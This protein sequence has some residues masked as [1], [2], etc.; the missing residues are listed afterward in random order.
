MES[1]GRRFHRTEA[2][3]A[4]QGAPT[5][6]KEAV[7]TARPR[8]S[9]RGGSLRPQAEGGSLQSE[10]PLERAWTQI[11]ITSTALWRGPWCHQMN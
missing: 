2:D 5:I 1:D 9:R 4:G 3:P 7:W 10:R 6:G 11:S 8:L